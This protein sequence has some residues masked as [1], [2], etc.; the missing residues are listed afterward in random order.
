[1]DALMRD[2]GLRRVTLEDDEV[3][4]SVA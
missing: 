3:R 4:L 2:V 1:V